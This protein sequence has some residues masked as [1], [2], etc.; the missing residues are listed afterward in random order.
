[1]R[2]EIVS[3]AGF[4]KSTATSAVMCAENLRIEE[5]RPVPGGSWLVGKPLSEAQIRRHTNLLVLAL[6]DEDGAGEG[7]F[8]F[9]TLA[10]RPRSRRG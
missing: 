3:R 2:R 7:R 10:R 4:M 8:L 1:M 9:T 5:V 6:R